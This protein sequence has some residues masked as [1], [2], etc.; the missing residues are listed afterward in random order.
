MPDI[1]EQVFDA[2]LELHPSDGGV[3]LFLP[4]DVPEVFGQKGAVQV[5]GTLDGFP[6][7]LSLS[8]DEDGNYILK[9]DKHLRNTIGKT[10]GATVHVAL[11][12]DTDAPDF[13]LPADLQRALERV[14][15]V[16]RFHQLPYPDRREFVQWI[17]RAK[18]PEARMAR[19]QEAVDGARNGRG[20][21]PGSY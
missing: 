11:R 10:W 6:F 14:G 1:P 2:E 5:R 20:R 4:F 3:F 19:I 16:S 9:V 8:L 21:R 18:K 15:L 7:R 13:E 17:S 12:P